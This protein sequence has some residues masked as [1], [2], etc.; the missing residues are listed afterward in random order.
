[1]IF[2]L[3]H[4]KSKNNDILLNYKLM[5]KRVYLPQRVVE[6]PLQHPILTFLAFAE[7]R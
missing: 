1:M 2:S 6:T 5:I 7:K 3:P 4:V